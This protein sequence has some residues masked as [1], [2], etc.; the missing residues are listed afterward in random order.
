MIEE[1]DSC[2]VNLGKAG[3]IPRV[4]TKS[5]SR[6]RPC[7]RTLELL[8]EGLGKASIAGLATWRGRALAFLPDAP[9]PPGPL[10]LA[11]VADAVADAVVGEEVGRVGG[12][13]AELGPDLLHDAAALSDRKRSRSNSVEVRERSRPATVTCRAPKSIQRS[14]RA[15]DLPFLPCPHVDHFRPAFHVIPTPQR[16]I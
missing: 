8:P 12:S 10:R 1:P 3:V 2:G 14:P 4:P 16:A 6:T 5:E 15:H 7:Q 13:G 11:R 9:D